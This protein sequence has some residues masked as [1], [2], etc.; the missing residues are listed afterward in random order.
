MPKLKARR[1]AILMVPFI[2]VV[3]LVYGATRLFSQSP[4]PV[5]PPVQAQPAQQT[6]AALPV[7]LT[8]TKP[9][10]VGHTVE[11]ADV[12]WRSWGGDTTGLVTA[13]SGGAAG[14]QRQ[15]ALLGQV[16]G[17]ALTVPALAGIPVT[18][19]QA[20]APPPPPVPP[21][22]TMKVGNHQ[23]NDDA[24]MAKLML[25]EEGIVGIG[26]NHWVSYADFRDHV[27]VV[28][29]DA[30]T[31][32]AV[33][34]VDDQLRAAILEQPAGAVV[35]VPVGWQPHGQSR[36]WANDRIYFA[37]AAADP[38]AVGA[39]PPLPAPAKPAAAPAPAPAPLAVKAGGPV[40][41][42]TDVDS[43]LAPTP[44]K[45]VVPPTLTPPVLPSGT[46]AVA[47]QK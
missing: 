3:G 5:P 22:P 16:V 32:K 11:A 12:V 30:V 19:A 34:E 15:A 36:V 23:L 8:W 20:E 44:A 25:R 28:G 33:I 39:L 38:A 43:L 26:S 35:A 27:V 41:K 42:L 2:V 29:A 45:P 14:E 10:D 6:A 7:V 1:V 9:L 4:V 47:A 21:K 46:P 31:G 17:R 18:M 40:T 13:Q 37:E 24:E